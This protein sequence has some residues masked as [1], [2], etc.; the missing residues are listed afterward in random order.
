VRR[1]ANTAARVAA[2]LAGSVVVHIGIAAVL[3]A[4]AI[5]VRSREVPAGIIEG[6][7]ITLAAP[8]SSPTIEAS[9]A[10]TP[11]TQAALPAPPTPPNVAS[12]VEMPDS[13]AAKAIGSRLEP[14]AAPIELDAPAVAVASF[15]GMDSDRAVAVVYVVDASGSM[16]STIDW[17]LK[18]LERSID[19][20]SSTQR[21]QIVMFSRRPDG[22]AYQTLPN[23]DGKGSLLP[24]TAANKRAAREWL[25][26]VQPGG[27][28]NP[29]D[30]LR[31]AL[32]Y[33]P[34]AVFLLSR[35]I[36]RSGEGAQWGKGREAILAELDELNP[37]NSRLGRRRTVIKTIQFVEEDPTGTMQAIGEIHGGERGHTLLTVRDLER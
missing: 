13:P 7:E 26:T 34:D 9:P 37:F 27:V 30:G 6:V 5:T 12:R 25:R 1:L 35:S 20:L 15:A 19:A 33:S 23:P 21:F 28:S 10:T 14:A 2:P 32:R 36:R 24:A 8:E 4:A 11:V 17:V 16:I 31:R 3:I 18:E 29:S 22:S